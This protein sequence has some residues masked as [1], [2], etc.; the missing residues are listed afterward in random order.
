VEEP[1][2]NQGSQQLVISNPQQLAG[3]LNKNTARETRAMVRA[4]PAGALA[5]L[6]QMHR[7]GVGSPRGRG[8]L[9]DEI[10]GEV[11]KPQEAQNLVDQ[12]LTRTAVAE[13]LVQR[14]GLPSVA[15]EVLDR[16]TIIAALVLDISTYTPRNITPVFI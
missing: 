11:A 7:D 9:F 10:L 3:L 1:N 13:L 15:A 5:V 2:Q 4:N 14:A 8:F 12:H 16:E 6:V